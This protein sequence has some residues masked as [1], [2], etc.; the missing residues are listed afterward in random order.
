MDRR[1]FF[2]SPASLSRIVAEFLQEGLDRGCPCILISTAGL[3][4]SVL[5]GLTERS[6]DPHALQ[7]A[8]RI[9]CFDADEMLSSFM[10]GGKPDVRKFTN[11]MHQAM[12]S[13]SAAGTEHPVYFFTQAIDVLWQQDKRDAAIRLEVLWNQLAEIVGLE[14]RYSLGNFCK[15]IQQGSE[16][17][18]RPAS[19]N[20]LDRR[21]RS[22][23]T[24]PNT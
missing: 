22:G 5:H 19:G 20:L 3:R 2:D 4:T 13:V 17:E 8:R 9:V 18:Q 14:Y 1:R 7:V 21:G 16:S 12:A 10:A 15:G 24:P 23:R 6:L 11:Q